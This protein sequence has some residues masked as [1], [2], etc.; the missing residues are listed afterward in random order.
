MSACSATICARSRRLVEALGASAFIGD[1]LIGNPE[2][3]RRRPLRAAR[4]VARGGA[5]RD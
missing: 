3:Q 1:A 5:P 2:T 4:A